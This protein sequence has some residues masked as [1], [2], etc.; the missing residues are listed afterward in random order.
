M[1]EGFYEIQKIKNQI[2]ANN[3]TN[4]KDFVDLFF[5][6]YESDSS[7]N[8]RNFISVIR[9]M[10]LKVV[11]AGVGY[12]V[13]KSGLNSLLEKRVLEIEFKRDVE[14]AS[15]KFPDFPQSEPYIYIKQFVRKYGNDPSYEDFS[16]LKLLLE[17][18][19]W[20]FSSGEL[21][22]FVGEENRKHFSDAVKSR[23]L[24]DNPQ[25][26]EEI[27]KSYLNYFQS[28]NIE[29]LSKLAEIL[30]EKSLMFSNLSTLKTELENIEKAIE[31]ESF[32]RRLTQEDA[33]IDIEDVDRLG[34]YEF[35][36]FLKKLYIK[37]GYQVEQT[38]LSGDQGADLVVIKF[39]EK[40]VIQA[41]CYSGNVGNYAVQEIF[42]AMN[43]Y[44]AHKGM[45]VTNSYFTPAA[46]EL[47]A[48]N[49]VELID[50][51][52]L[53]ELIRKFW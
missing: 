11:I 35:E 13:D 41:K 17:N 39:G 4:V 18:R 44:K 28:N 14:R 29:M 48:A 3:P 8:L 16:N 21:S 2:L 19:G 53:K 46:F 50:R 15:A 42:A 27:L 7:V 30:I 12:E 10:Q 51:S 45:V 34:G 43:L 49:N 1:N 31:I 22:F 32:E 38:R 52:S 40:T 9:E 37:M 20:N 47:A 36:G 24:S 23:I 6:M 26:R 33:Q 25:S 5:R